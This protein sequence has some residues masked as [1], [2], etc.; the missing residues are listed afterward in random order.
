MR[1]PE[2][3]FGLFF[4]WIL[5]PDRPEPVFH[6]LRSVTG[7]EPPYV[8]R[9][10]CGKSDRLRLNIAARLRIDHASLFARPCRI[11]FPDSP[12]WAESDFYE[13]TGD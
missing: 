5:N 10:A 11:C 1:Q 12:E 6:R 2:W 4:V 9:M 3:A 13:G 8:F 7:P